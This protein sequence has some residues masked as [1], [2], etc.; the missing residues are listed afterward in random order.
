MSKIENPKILLKK[1]VFFTTCDE[2]AHK[3]KKMWFIFVT[4][5]KSY[6]S[7]VYFRGFLCHHILMTK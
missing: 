4:I 6:F 3:I 5:K 2:N 1:G 7:V